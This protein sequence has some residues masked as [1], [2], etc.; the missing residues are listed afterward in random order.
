VTKAYNEEQVGYYQPYKINNQSQQWDLS[1]YNLPFIP[2]FDYSGAL[3]NLTIS[4]NGTLGDDLGGGRYSTLQV[5]NGMAGFALKR[6]AK[7][8]DS[9]KQNSSRTL[10]FSEASWAG[11]GSYSVG[12]L[13]G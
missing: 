2:A 3:D 4:L 5:R 13:T 8:V 11:S 9:I 7:V 10:L 6:T 1:T 12:L